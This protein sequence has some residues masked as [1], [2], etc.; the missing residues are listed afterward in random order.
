MLLSFIPRGDVFYILHDTHLGYSDN[1]Q[2][3]LSGSPMMKI[4][5]QTEG[6]VA[7]TINLITG[8]ICRLRE[9]IYVI[10][11]WIPGTLVFEELS[12]QN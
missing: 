12:M 6:D 9:D 1:Q 3:P 8:E 7:N 10:R 5:Y 11:A 4:A 2:I